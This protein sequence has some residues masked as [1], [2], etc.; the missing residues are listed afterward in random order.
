MYR[1]ASGSPLTANTPRTAPRPTISITTTYPSIRIMFLL[2]SAGP[3]PRPARAAMSR[4]WIPSTLLARMYPQTA[5]A[6]GGNPA[7]PGQP[8]AA[9]SAGRPALPAIMRIVFGVLWQQGQRMLIDDDVADDLLGW[10]R[11]VMGQQRLPVQRG[12]VTLVNVPALGRAGR[13]SSTNPT[14]L[15]QSQHQKPRA[16]RRRCR[17]QTPWATEVRSDYLH[18]TT[19]EITT[20]IGDSEA[21]T[22]DRHRAHDEGSLPSAPDLGRLDCVRLEG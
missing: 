22:P 7:A 2:L 10:D 11:I 8:P 15:T 6:L 19:S 20:P 4:G 21:L 1:R 3:R 12:S 16:S 18:V 13:D 9:D 14:G 17:Q 5:A